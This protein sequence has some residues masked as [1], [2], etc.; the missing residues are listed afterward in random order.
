MRNVF[1]E[2]T[3]PTVGKQGQKREIDIVDCAMSALAMF[4]LKFLSLLQFDKGK[5]ERTIK[6]NLKNFSPMKKVKH[7]SSGM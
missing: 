2:L 5:D 1:K 6:Q 3:E 7:T 4:K